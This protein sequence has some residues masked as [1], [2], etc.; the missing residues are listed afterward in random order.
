MITQ[1]QRDVVTLLES[2]DTYGGAEVERIDTHT[3]AVFMAGSHAYK[4]KRAVRYD[5][6]DFSTAHLRRRFCEAEVMLNRR[7]APNLYKR[8]VAVTKQDDGSLALDGPGT[9]VDWVIEMARFPQECLFDR[10]ASEGRLS[11]EV[12]AQLAEHI[13]GFHATAERRFDHGGR[14]GMQWVADG[15]ASGFAEFGTFIEFGARAHLTDAT[16]RQ[17]RRHA[18]VL[19]ARREGGSVR[20]CHGDLHLGNIVLL[21][22]QPTLFDGIE[23]ND[24]IACIDVLYDLAFLVMDLWHRE[25]PRHGNLL[26]NRYLGET[27]DLD[28]L[29]LMPLFL[30]CRAAIRAKTSATAARMQTNAQKR[31]SLEETGRAYFTMATQLLEEHPPQLIAIGGLSGS[32]KSTLAMAIAPSIGRVPGALVLRSDELR[33]RLCNIGLNERLEP[34]GYSTQITERVYRTLAEHATR[35]LRAGHSVIVDA[36]FAD[37]D[38]RRHVE[39]IARDLSLRFVGLWLDSPAST[40]ITRVA[41]RQHDA[42]DADADVVRLQLARA[43]GDVTWQRLDA[44]V[45]PEQ[46]ADAAR[47]VVAGST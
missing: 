31:A 45:A 22:G 37:E 6:L 41:A 36:V 20:H 34:S 35:A 1:E 15:D 44:S 38:E 10:M 12:V 47:H 4:L 26:V 13:A 3:A 23:F 30:S 5:Y 40:L 28:G 18:T 46:V 27:A 2:P 33:K 39:H 21:D 16:N 32:G 24:E 43:V 42:S 14:Q 19:D 17:I 25:L 8:V 9:P 29:A 11:L 7:T